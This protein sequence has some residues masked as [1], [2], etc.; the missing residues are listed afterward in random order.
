MTNMNKIEKMASNGWIVFRLPYGQKKT[1]PKG[2]TGKKA[3]T[4]DA[5]ESM[6]KSELALYNEKN[7]NIGI[8]M[9]MDVVGI[10]V[11]DSSTLSGRAVR[12][13]TQGSY[14]ITST[15]GYERYTAYYRLPE[16]VSSDALRNLPDEVDL[17]T[18]NHRYSVIGGHPSGR[19]YRILDKDNNEI[20]SLPDWADLDT[21]PTGVMNIMKREDKALKSPISVQKSNK[22]Q[23]DTS[24]IEM[25]HTA[26]E[27]S[28]KVYN[29][30]LEVMASSV[31][32][33]NGF[34]N[35][36]KAL[37]AENQKGHSIGVLV[38]LLTD[39]F[40]SMSGEDRTDEAMRMVEGL[41]WIDSPCTDCDNSMGRFDYGIMNDA[42]MEVDE[43]INEV[44][45]RIAEKKIEFPTSNHKK[46][47]EKKVSKNMMLD[48]IAKSKNRA[49][50]EESYIKNQIVE[51]K[52][53][54]YNSSLN[55]IIDD[56]STTEEEKKI[57]I[58]LSFGYD[59]KDI[60]REVGISN[61]T[62]KKRLTAMGERYK[63][64]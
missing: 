6:M 34:L 64:S 21:L 63:N 52:T 15:D 60:T 42:E 10:D 7:N 57:A 45:I 2:F 38:K 18:H 39:L 13:L 26:C 23:C 56:I 43:V 11:D 5:I 47:F 30:G 59:R 40:V 22:A 54:V 55:T 58:M 51:G 32:R 36:V 1:P 62:L 12:D 31:S 20:E 3:I 24:G 46:A 16:G 33:H 25:A 29:K 17:I 27:R 44:W 4:G 49:K 14:R 8:R 37:N 9:P 48:R 35:A 53:E 50:A 28:T 41:G 61:P 19:Q